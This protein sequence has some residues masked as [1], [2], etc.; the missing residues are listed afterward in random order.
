LKEEDRLTE[1]RRRGRKNKEE[2]NARRV[3]LMKRVRYKG[4][5]GRRKNEEKD[6]G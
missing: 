2:E 1:Y 4:E 3:V 6:G 5:G